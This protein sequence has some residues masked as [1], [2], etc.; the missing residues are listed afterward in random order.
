MTHF[1]DTFPTVFGPFSVAVDQQGA[2]VATAFGTRENL[3]ERLSDCRLIDDEK[4][5]APTQLIDDKAKTRPIRDQVLAYCAGELTQ[6]TCAIAWHGTAFQQRVWSALQKI[7]FS[8][9]RSYGTLAAE[10][11]NPSASRAVGRA[12]ATNPVCLIVPCHRVIGADGSL[13]G[14][15]FG[16]DIKRRLLEHER[17]IATRS[18]AA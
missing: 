3:R 4:S 10:L 1:V 17:S 2:A 18:R 6:F 15:A 12:N 9:T 16:E 13:T 7:P 8:E 14:F 11:G 5:T